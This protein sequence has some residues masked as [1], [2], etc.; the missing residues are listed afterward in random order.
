MNLII[1]KPG[2]P[3]IFI[4]EVAKVEYLGC[5]ENPDPLAM[6]NFMADRLMES[7]KVKLD[8]VM[9]HLP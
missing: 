7:L 6:L 3:P 2:L 8:F 9:T 1:M 5:F 4:K